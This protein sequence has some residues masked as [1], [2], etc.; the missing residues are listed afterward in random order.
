[1]P[2][3]TTTLLLYPRQ[4]RWSIH[5]EDKRDIKTV[6]VVLQYGQGKNIWVY[7]WFSSASSGV[8]R[9]VFT[10]DLSST[11]KPTLSFQKDGYQDNFLYAG[12]V[13]D[14]LSL[15]GALKAIIEGSATVL[16]FTEVGSQ[17]ASSL[18]LADVD[19]VI[20]YN[21]DF[22]IGGK[23]YDYIRNFDLS[24]SNNHNPDGYGVASLDRQYHQKG[25]TE[26]T[27]TMVVRLDSDSFAERAKVFADT[28]VALSFYFKGDDIATDVPELMLIE[29]PYCS[30]QN[31]DFSENAGVFDASMG[32]KATKPK[33]TIYNEPITITMLN[34]DSA[35][36]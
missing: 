1:M 36:Y 12:C 31:F 24:I 27:G 9:H 32:F 25:K 35:V 23:D 30:L 17:N 8:Y 10:A 7:V 19:P 20:F 5:Q 29:L 21:G 4:V 33:G 26:I 6:A 22:S 3:D 15:S 13:V 34:T 14:V 18:S 16:G 2:D 11:E 28:Q